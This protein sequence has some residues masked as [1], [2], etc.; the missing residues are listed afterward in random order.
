MNDW[1][2]GLPHLVKTDRANV[3]QLAELELAAPQA[4]TDKVELADAWWEAA[5][6]AVSDEK[7]AYQRRA[8]H[9]YQAALPE[10][11][12]LQKIKVEKRLETLPDV[13]EP[14]LVARGDQGHSAHD[15]PR[16]VVGVAKPPQLKP[17]AALKAQVVP[18]RKLAGHSVFVWEA[19]FSNDGAVIFTKAHS[20]T[21]GAERSVKIWSGTTGELIHTFEEGKDGFGPSVPTTISRDGKSLVA[22][23]TSTPDKFWGDTLVF[24]DAATGERK[25]ELPIPQQDL[26]VRGAPRFTPSGNWLALGAERG[27]ALYDTSDWQRRK[28]V[29]CFG[30]QV[31]SWTVSDDLI[32]VSK[33]GK[34]TIECWSIESG[35]IEFEV[36]VSREH[37]ALSISP[38]Q[39]LLAG[40][41]GTHEIR[42]HDLEN[43][44][45]PQVL[46]AEM[47]SVRS[48]AFSPWG[49]IMASGDAYKKLILWDCISGQL[50]HEVKCEGQVSVVA[51]S[52]DGKRLLSAQTDGQVLL[53]N[54]VAQQGP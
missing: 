13:G 11:A 15:A 22:V 54:V 2:K 48:T 33:F 42:L 29:E 24:W 50:L 20:N 37:A 17:D 52:P 8:R 12:G 35:E 34:P 19:M 21:P 3:R 47:G 23:Q 46:R 39:K 45:T 49:R 41:P 26:T 31:Y 32:A 53:W 18:A 30:G 10:L 6:S 38:D 28:V 44:R 16:R 40:A 14:L 36:P 5:K 1:E 9:W 25:K 27:L 51:F 43:R 7:D 4:V